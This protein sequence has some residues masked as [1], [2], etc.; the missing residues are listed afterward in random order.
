MN[1]PADLHDAHH[2]GV[3]ETAKGN[4]VCTLRAAIEEANGRIGHD[5]IYIQLPAGS[6]IYLNLGHLL[7]EDDLAISGKGAGA[8]IIDADGT[9]TLDRAFVLSFAKVSIYDLTIQNALS[10]GADGG[11]IFSDR[12]ELHL[13]GVAFVND[14]AGSNSGGAVAASEGLVELSGCDVG[15]NTGTDGAGLT[16]RNGSLTVTQSRIHDNTG[17]AGILLDDTAA[18]IRDSTIDF[19]HGR[20]VEVVGTSSLDLIDSTVTVNYSNSN[21]G[22]LFVDTAGALRTFNATI[23]GNRC[24]LGSAGGGIWVAA[25]DNVSIEN[26]ILAQNTAAGPSHS[27]IPDD[28]NGVIQSLDYNLVQ[29]TA[30]CSLTGSVANTQTGFDDPGIGPLQDNGGPTPTIAL[31]SGSPGIDGGNPGGCTDNF[32]AILTTDQRGFPRPID[33]RCDIG[34]FEFGSALPTPTPTRTAIP[35]K[36]RTPTVTSTRTPTPVPPTA[37]PTPTKTPT[38]TPTRTLTPVPPTATRTPTRT[39]TRTATAI[40]PTS[41]PTRTPTAVSGSVLPQALVVDSSGDGVFEPGKTVAVDPSWKDT[42]ASPVSLTS[43]ATLFTGP[44]GASYGILDG[45]A[46]YGSIPAGATESCAVAADCYSMT[47]VPEAS[48]PATHWDATFTETT[49]A[50]PAKVW[51][52]HIGGSFTDVPASQL[53]YKKIETLLH[54][55]ITTGCTGAA[56]CPDQNVPRSQM[57][58][59][60]AKGMAGG[61]GN[62]PVSGT[63]GVAS[64]NCTSGGVSLFSDVLP[65]D[66]FCKHVHYIASKNVTSGCSAG[67]YCPNDT[68]SRLEMASFIAKAVVAPSGGGGIPQT[69]GPDP[70]TGLSYSCDTGSPNVHF[71]DVPATDAFCKHV[72][73]LWAK[74][75]IAGCSGTTYC[76][77]GTVSRDQMAKFLVNA[78]RLGL[79]GP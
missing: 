62:V 51:T 44:P 41:S 42:S 5:D 74:G 58:I 55:G 39:P 59:F 47:V 48:R 31:L 25:G 22:G 35:T 19:N 60:I 18:T 9:A 50:G 49:S 8:T 66:S 34:A 52:L 26:T 17:L 40:P 29:T 33:G 53:F 69:Y 71:T 36:T 2:D 1:S 6:T 11:G 73:Y 16:I 78:F 46:S 64:Y 79:Y 76:P 72:H 24:G 3:C 77:A 15:G 56:Y 23:V 20:G 43:T 75:I 63:V 32:G 38:R 45:S 28:C 13:Y 7:V 57:A 12:T 67:K 70:A 30:G 54:S 10:V 27:V 14:S 37:T 61:G 65:T 4:G 68:L 21:G